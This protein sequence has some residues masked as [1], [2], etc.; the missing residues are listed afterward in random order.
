MHFIKQKRKQHVDDDAVIF[1]LTLTI[2]KHYLASSYKPLWFCGVMQPKL[3]YTT[4]LT[5]QQL[6]LYICVAWEQAS[7]GRTIVQPKCQFGS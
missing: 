1:M 7:W 4:L 2:Y 5:W 6:A 3:L